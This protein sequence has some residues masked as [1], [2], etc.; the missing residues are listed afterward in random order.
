MTEL[1]SCK[2]LMLVFAFYI[3]TRMLNVGATT[4]WPSALQVQGKA[5]FITGCD[6]GFGHALAKHLHKLGFT[7]F[8]G[9]LLKV[10]VMCFGFTASHYN[11]LIMEGPVALAG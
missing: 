3:C 9:C 4:A 6:S 10:Q 1:T 7:V 8:A 5:V 11:S 2:C